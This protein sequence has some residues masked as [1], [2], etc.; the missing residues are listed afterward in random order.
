VYVLAPTEK[1]LL[2]AIFDV[3]NPMEVSTA[4]TPC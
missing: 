4:R 3:E 1:T 2:G